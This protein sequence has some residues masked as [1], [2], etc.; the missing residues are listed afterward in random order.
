MTSASIR[1]RSPLASYHPGSGFGNLHHSSGGG[2]HQCLLSYSRL[3]HSNSAPVIGGQCRRRRLSLQSLQS[4]D[5][6]EC[7]VLGEGA[8]SKLRRTSSEVYVDKGGFGV[9]AILVAY[10]QIYQTL[11]NVHPLEIMPTCAPGY[12]ISFDAHLANAGPDIDSPERARKADVYTW[13]TEY[14]QQ[15]EL[16]QSHQQPQAPRDHLPEDHTHL[17]RGHAPSV[18]GNSQKLVVRAEEQVPT[19]QSSSD[20]CRIPVSSPQQQLA[21]ESERPSKKSQATTEE[22][23][24]EENERDSSATEVERHVTLQGRTYESYKTVC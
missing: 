4:Y 14:K 2:H 22:D 20:E 8:V 5:F 24:D 15:K 18:E 7:V 21:E 3:R 10:I 1:A 11:I 6:D 23:K 17:H 13:A 19:V 9:L 16:S 12:I